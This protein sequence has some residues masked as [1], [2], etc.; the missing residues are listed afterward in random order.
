[1]WLPGAERSHGEV[2]INEPLCEVTFLYV[3][4][5]HRGKGKGTRLL[6]IAER[7][8]K[9]CGCTRAAV[10]STPESISFYKGRGYKSARHKPSLMSKP[11]SKKHPSLSW[12]GSI[13]FDL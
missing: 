11:L 8:L 13:M 3:D 7:R 4:A 6:E 5:P 1:M 9:D 12:P 2:M 10:I